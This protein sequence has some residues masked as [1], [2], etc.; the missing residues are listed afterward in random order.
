MPI[1]CALCGGLG[2]KMVCD[3]CNKELAKLNHTA[4]YKLM[5]VF[6]SDQQK[7]IKKLKPEEQEQPIDD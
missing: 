1:K 2:N 5:R 7:R 3:S 6:A 4:F